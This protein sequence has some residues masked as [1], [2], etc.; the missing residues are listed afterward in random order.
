MD[1]QPTPFIW[2]DA[3]PS[4]CL[5]QDMESDRVIY[6]NA[7]AIQ[8]LKL[9]KTPLPSQLVSDLFRIDSKRASGIWRRNGRRYRIHEQR[10]DWGGN[11]YKQLL[12]THLAPAISEKQLQDAQRMAQVLVHRLRSPL[13]GVIGF[14]DMLQHADSADDTDAEWSSLT[15]GLYTIRDLLDELDRFTQPIDP[16]EDHLNVMNL[17]D[18]VLADLPSDLRRSID[19]ETLSTPSEMKGDPLFFRFIIN[20][21]LANA[22]EANEDELDSISI[23]LATSEIKVRNSGGHLSQLQRKQL[24]Q[25]FFTTKARHLGLGLAQAW[26][27][28]HTLGWDL[29]YED[30]SGGSEHTF[31]LRW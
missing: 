10:I 21:L 17:V 11:S 30:S 25:P 18:E 19:I 8:E 26:R 9:P 31:V 27:Y 16:Q 20:E 5:V 24:F 12:I 4:A 14:A 13:N 15:K 28:A 7:A 2:L 23:Q 29:Y 6:A 1:T 3:I 22:L